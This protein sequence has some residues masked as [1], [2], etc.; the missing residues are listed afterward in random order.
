[1]QTRR[2]EIQ[3]QIEQPTIQEVSFD[4]IYQALRNFSK[5]LPKVSQEKQK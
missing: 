1:M 3:I 4:K 5:V 2:S